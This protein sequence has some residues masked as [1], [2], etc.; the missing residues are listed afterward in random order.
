MS[1]PLPRDPFT[2]A[3]ARAAGYSA[4]KIRHHLDTGDWL[5]LL[6]GVYCTAVRHAYAGTSPRLVHEL[7]VLAAQ[8]AVRR[9]TVASGWS[10]AFLHGWPMPITWGQPPSLITLTT[11]S[12]YG[13]A[14]PGVS[15][16]TGPLEDDQVVLVSDVRTTAPARTAVDVAR[17][18]DNSEIADA[19]SVADAVLHRGDATRPELEALVDRFRRW[20]GN[21]QARWIIQR[22][23]SRAESR[24]SRTPGSCSSG[25]RC[26][27]RN[28]RSRS[29]T[30]GASGRPGRLPL[31]RDEHDR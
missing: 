24:S 6:R 1:G 7:D 30:I 20:P 21:E 10:A 5:A 18:A 11:T 28:P 3:D 16:R 14:I 22:V 26:P 27:R 23:D 17:W 13:K 4:G 29:T 19:L 25:S 2:T 31:A 15:L 12:R 8:L 9:P